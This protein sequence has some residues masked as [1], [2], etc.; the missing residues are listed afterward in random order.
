MPT[1]ILRSGNFIRPEQVLREAGVREGMQVV[2]LGCGPG[3]YVIPAAKF[4]GAKGRVVAI[5]IRTPALEEV[6]QRARMENLENIDVI[7][8]DVVRE[9][10]SQLPDGWADLVILA[11]VLHLSD[12]RGVLA[13]ASRVVRPSEGRV[14]VI[15]WELVNIPIGPPVEQ[16]VAPDVVLASA[17]SANLVLLRRWKPSPYHYSFLFA[18]AMGREE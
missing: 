14:L 12:P 10:G 9:E 2:H 18:K 3:F 6:S 1:H 8:A 4:V 5:D 16:R 11:N 15:E 13:E 7:R 17:R